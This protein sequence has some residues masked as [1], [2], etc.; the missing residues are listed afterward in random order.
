MLEFDQP[1]GILLPIKRN[2]TN[3]SRKFE[4]EGLLNRGQTK[5]TSSLENLAGSPTNTTTTMTFLNFQQ[6]IQKWAAEAIL[7]KT[8]TCLALAV[9]LSVHV[10]N[11]ASSP[12]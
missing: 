8:R 9:R 1:D 3:T 12:S 5:K 11:M 2:G 7:S 4:T 6:N 10:L